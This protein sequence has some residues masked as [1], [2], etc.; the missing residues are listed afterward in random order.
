MKTFWRI[1][2]HADLSGKG[3]R[4]SSARWHT[5]GRPIVYLSDS[6][7][8]AML[9]RIVHLQDGNGKLPPTYDL[10]RIEAPEVLAIRDLMPLAETGWKE[11]IE[12]SRGLGDA[13]LV[14]PESALA[15]VPSAIVP[16]TWNYLF[17]PAHPGAGHVAIAEVLRERFDNRLFR[18]GAP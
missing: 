12:A 17:N 8:S 1:S 6:P 11:K 9:E 15:R 3:G 5:Q 14:S 16:Y 4:M 7:S 10:L 2:S 13:W 18:F